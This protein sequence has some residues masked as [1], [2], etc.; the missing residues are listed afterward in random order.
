MTKELHVWDFLPEFIDALKFQLQ[1]DEQRWGNTWLSRQREGQEE[2]TIAK[3]NDYF[4]Q[5]KE[6]NAPLPWLRIAGGALI[7]WIRD[8]HPEIWNDTGKPEEN[9]FEKELAL[10]KNPVIKS[11][12]ERAVALLPE[13]FY[14]VAASSTGKYHPN[15]ALGNGGLYRHVRASVG[16]AVDLFRI[17]EFT[18]DE[19]DLIITSLILHDGWK[20]GENGSGN[21]THTHPIVASKMLKE[22]IK[23]SSTE[24]KEFLEIICSNIEAHMGQWTTVKYDSTVLPS[25]QTEMENFVHECDYLSSR[26][27]IEFN[28]SVRE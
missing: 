15:F 9:Y 19:Q 1:N 24:E 13:Y 6:K 16:I 21:S 12:A 26:K 22:G 23:T 10:I 4:D 11:I 17:Y 14:K 8:Q 18:P 7:C 2:R 5:Y 3:F 28:F 27:D 20:Q 25:P